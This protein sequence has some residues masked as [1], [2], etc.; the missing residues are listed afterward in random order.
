[1]GKREDEKREGCREGF[2][3]SEIPPNPLRRPGSSCLPWASVSHSA[4]RSY[5]GEKLLIR[6]QASPILRDRQ[7]GWTLAP[8]GMKDRV[9][10][11]GQGFVGPALVNPW[12]SC[13]QVPTEQP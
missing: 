12:A 13:G 1:M 3:L 7:V 4:I 6:F 2:L 9:I 11:V 5:T 8:Q 10:L